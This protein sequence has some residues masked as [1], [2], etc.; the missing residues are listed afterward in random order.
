M[1][2]FWARFG[3]RLRI[4]LAAMLVVA[5]V[6]AATSV[7]LVRVQQRQ[8]L[9]NLD[10][11]LALRADDLQGEI[12][13]SEGDPGA[14][15]IS[16][17]EE[18]LAQ[19]VDSDGQVIAATPGLGRSPVIADAPLTGQ[20]TRTVRGLPIEDDAYRILSRVVETT[21]GTFVLHLGQNTDDLDDSVRIL[22][23]SLAVLIPLVVL[24]LGTVLWWLVGRTLRPVE[25]IRL[26]VAAIGA[27]DLH[28]RVPRPPTSD[29]ISRLASTMNAM[30]DRLEE[31]SVRQHRFVADASHELRSP[32]TRIRAEVELALAQDGRDEDGD[33]SV[34]TSVLDDTTELGRLV[35]DLLHLA[36]SDAGVSSGIYEPVDLDDIVLREARRLRANDCQVDLSH[37]SAAHLTGCPTDLARAV[38]NLLDNAARHATTTV[39]VVLGETNDAVRLEVIDDGPG[40]PPTDRKRIFERFTRLDDA[41]TRDNGGTGLGLAIARDIIEN[42]GGRLV[43]QDTSQGDATGARFVATLPCS[44]PEQLAANPRT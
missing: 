29:E 10:T 35:A 30:L 31:A 27:S 42:H 4:T 44:P 36:R 43:V 6:L 3:I 24:V 8:L 40:V 20:V 41:R 1:N 33:T 32:L 18:Q 25:D 12:V 26:E 14:F 23:A 5:V 2:R 22:T 11:T 38:R 28:R 37:L 19:L 9:A 34:L 39:T 17:G 21:A 16:A 15:S 7:A 13:A